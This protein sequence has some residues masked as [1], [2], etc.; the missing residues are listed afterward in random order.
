VLARTRP[1]LALARLR[2]TRPPGVRRQEDEWGERLAVTG[3]A[4]ETLR[5]PRQAAAAYR[6]AMEEES[7][8]AE[9]LRPRL[10][11]LEAIG[12]RP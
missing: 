11:A 12:A 9:E 4:L 3:L 7:W 6:R 2:E 10:A 8:L 5:R 1:S